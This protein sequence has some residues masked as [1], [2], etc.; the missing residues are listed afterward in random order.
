MIAA[1]ELRFGNWVDTTNVEAHPWQTGQIGQL[2]ANS[3]GILRKGQSSFDGGTY[4][5]IKPIPL[6]EE[7]LLKCGF[8]LK[9]ATLNRLFVLEHTKDEI[10]EVCFDGGVRLWNGKS[11]WAQHYDSLWRHIKY[12]HQLQNLYFALTGQ[13]LT[14]KESEK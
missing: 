5:Q 7:W 14:F 2:L 6:T 9:E 13:E 11:N 8:E 1:S 10:L 3:V 4:D 12:V